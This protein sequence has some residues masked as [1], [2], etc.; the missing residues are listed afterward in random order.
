MS[1][2]TQRSRA[3]A[4]TQTSH[5]AN[6]HFLFRP[7]TVLSAE[8]ENEGRETRL[9]QLGESL[10]KASMHAQACLVQLKDDS[11]SSIERRD[12]QRAN[13]LLTAIATTALLA[14]HFRMAFNHCST[15]AYSSALAP[16][17]REALADLM[18]LC[19]WA[20]ELWPA[21]KWVS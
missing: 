18:S 10:A 21:P 19:D 5:A 16:G 1:S 12:C 3:H 2:I 15:G 7:I 17:P 4:S 13:A 8:M 20:D 11:A 6:L 9:E 14:G